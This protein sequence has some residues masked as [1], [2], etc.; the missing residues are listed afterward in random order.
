MIFMT[1][2]KDL[3]FNIL[4]KNVNQ[5]QESVFF[6]GLSYREKGVVADHFREL[7]QA[8]VRRGHR[9]VFI[10][11]QQRHDL[12][13]HSANPAFYTFPSMVP[14]KL[15]DLVFLLKLIY[16]YQP[17]CMI[18]VWRAV[19]LVV[20]AGWLTGVVNRV[21]W[22]R[23]TSKQSVFEI[24]GPSTIK[25]KYQVLRKKIIYHLA[26][27]IITSTKAMEK[28]LIS[29]YQVPEKK[30]IVFP[31][32]IR[33]PD[34][35]LLIL[36]RNERR[37]ICVGRLCNLKGQE[38]LL[39]AIVLLKSEFP[40]LSVDFFGGGDINS[41]QALA[42]DLGVGHMC[43]F[44]GHIPHDKVLENMATSAITIVPS[45]EEAFGYVNIESMAVGTPLIASNVGGIPEIIRDGI[46]GFLVPAND[47]DTLAYRIRHLLLESDLRKSMG[48]NAH[49]KFLEDYDQRNSIKLQVEFFESLK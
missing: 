14:S 6:I 31:N 39:Q 11:D 19:N 24:N 49:E 29:V 35:R 30:I 34:E 22:Y 15:V 12:E 26:T 45:K 25:R 48:K 17:K 46:D 10:I 20:L 4:R 9:V 7:A 3:K 28:D 47:A 23:T 44:H 13:N 43:Q 42:Q 41:F 40:D 16:Q 33:L 5:N 37:L 21:V 8:L 18:G 36:P 1:L 32:A 38:T 2:F 27:I